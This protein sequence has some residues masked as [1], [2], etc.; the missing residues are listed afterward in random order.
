MLSK[1]NSG[2]GFESLHPHTKKV[3]LKRVSVVFKKIGDTMGTRYRKPEMKLTGKKWYIEYWY[4]VPPEVRHLHENKTWK[5]FKFYKDINRVKTVEY[6]QLLCQQLTHILEMGYNPFEQLKE[7]ITSPD[8][9]TLSDSI[10]HFQETWGR[11]GLSESH[12]NK[13][14]RASDRLLTTCKILNIQDKGLNVLTSDIISKH[15]DRLADSEN[16]S[17]RTYNNE[18]D[19]LTTMFNF[20]KWDGIKEISPKKTK[21]TKHKFYGEQLFN[22]A[23]EIMAKEDPYLLFACQCVY[24]L[25]IRSENE[26]MNFKVM[27]IHKDRMQVFI[28]DGKTGQR[29]IPMSDE[30]LKIFEERGVF[31]YNPNFYVFSVPHKNKFLPDGNPRAEPFGTGFFSKRFRKLRKKIGLTSDYTIYGFKHTR[32]VHLKTDGI[33]DAD[34]MALT[35]H[36]DYKSYS[37]YMRDLGVNANPDNINKATRKL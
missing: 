32:V 14:V 34:I 30:M 37:A 29:Y 35:G 27:D 31:N 33:P 10:L 23:R 5:R 15:L 12:Y 6:A 18:L 20:L 1:I 26:L 13:L 9:V 11:K 17:N 16:W 28:S 36:T 3:D 7:E 2:N 21:P 25:C 22:K 24:F 19:C 4:K 8:I